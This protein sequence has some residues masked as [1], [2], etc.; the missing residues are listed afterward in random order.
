M[1]RAVAWAAL[2][3]ALPVLAA[4]SVAVWLDRQALDTGNWTSASAPLLR[5]AAVRDAV[6][7][8]LVDTL[9]RSR[10]AGP[11]ASA[12]FRRRA[13]PAVARLLETDQATVVWVS[14]NRQAHAALLRALDEP[15]GAD[16]VVMDLGPLAAEVAKPLGVRVTVPAGVGDVV[17][18]PAGR[19]EPVRR[20][21][22]TLVT[23]VTWLAIA[24]A[25]LLAVAFALGRGV[26]R[27]MLVVL[28]VGAAAIGV[29]LL[30]ARP[31]AGDAL[32]HRLAEPRYR[33]AGDAVWDAVSEMLSDIAIG[34]VA[35]GAVVAALAV[36]TAPARRRRGSGRLHGTRRR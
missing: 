14:A 10:G 4:F 32:V 7:G 11:S 25:A 12:A 21:A 2:W 28:G 27:R 34:L 19:L 33:D 22:D 35:G 15:D 6:A 31:R 36:L 29:L 3:L 20:A 13:R 26:R 24:L 9:A 5:N 1:R 30:L 16:P 8:E 18:V 17:V 23:A